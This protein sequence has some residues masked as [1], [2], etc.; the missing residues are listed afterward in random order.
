MKLDD[1][2]VIYLI[3]L[4]ESLGAGNAKINKITEYFGMPEN[5]YYA[6]VKE[7]AKAG[8]LSADDIENLEKNR[9]LSGAQEILDKCSKEEIS[10]CTVYDDNYPER[11][12]TIP[13]P[14][15]LF[16]YKGSPIWD[17]AA[18]NIA[19]VGSRRMTK[20][21]YDCA[22]KIAGE[23]TDCGCTV[24]S[25]MADGVDAAAQSAV[26]KV[27]GRT[28]AFLGGGVD[29]IYPQSNFMLYYDIIENG[30]VIS[31]FLPG[32]KNLPF[33]FQQR[34]RLLAGMSDGVLVVEAMKKSG[35]MITVKWAAEYNRDVFAVPGDIT[36]AM[37]EGT[38]DLISDG[39]KLTRNAMDILSEYGNLFS[40]VIEKK[41]FS[42]EK[43]MEI[44]DVSNIENVNA[45]AVI[46]A[47]KKG[48][49]DPS[50]LSEITDIPIAELIL[51]L[52]DLEIK[53]IITEKPGGIVALSKGV[54]I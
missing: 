2:S 9:D 39:A 30:C 12:Q 37:S 38:N 6:D 15:V 36:S 29:V 43:N 22:T 5:A 17:D 16:F 14:P 31:E 4:I 7:L 27:G 28:I 32:E 26:V 51:V 50:A 1:S 40:E 54:I 42:K 45:A 41:K 48:E 23:L 46:G 10:I 34:N 35:T 33:H 53:G 19:I 47:L 44:P 21:G 25:G 3:W 52:T 11:F 24:V 18:L 20:Y 13:N 49:Y 8:E